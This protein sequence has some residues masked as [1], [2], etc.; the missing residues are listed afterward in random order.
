MQINSTYRIELKGGGGWGR[1]FLLHCL[2]RLLLGDWFNR[3]CSEGPWEIQAKRFWSL[4][5]E[6]ALQRQWASTIAFESRKTASSI[7]PGLSLNTQSSKQ[8]KTCK[9]L[10]MLLIYF[11]THPDAEKHTGTHTHTDTNK[12]AHM[13]IIRLYIHTCTQCLAL[14][15]SYPRVCLL[16]SS[17]TF[18]QASQLSFRLTHV[19]TPSLDLISLTHS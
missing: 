19:H 14:S 16:S 4:S 1:H 8:M 13:Q 2:F 18:R 11:H 7:T 15:V 5:N 10:D 6:A 12:M 9:Q 17:L 3:A